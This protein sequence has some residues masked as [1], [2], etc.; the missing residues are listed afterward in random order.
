M[1]EIWRVPNPHLNEVGVRLT[2]GSTTDRV[3]IL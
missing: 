1:I 3:E 2:I